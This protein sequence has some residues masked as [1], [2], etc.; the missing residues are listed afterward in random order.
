ME[1]PRVVARTAVNLAIATVVRAL[2]VVVTVRALSV[3]K[4]RR[5]A[6]RKCSPRLVCGSR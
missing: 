2:S 3:V 6:M 4:D 5:R 1:G